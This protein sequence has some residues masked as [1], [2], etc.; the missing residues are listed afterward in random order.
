MFRSILGSLMC[1]CVVASQA[2]AQVLYN[3]GGFEPPRFTTTPFTSLEGQDSPPTGQG[4]WQKDATG[5]SPAFIQTTVVQSGLQAVQFNRVAASTGDT[6]YGVVK[7]TAAPQRISI[8]WDQRVNSGSANNP[9]FGV[10]A[11]DRSAGGAKLIGT[12]GLDGT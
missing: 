2:R 10:L 8:Q 3:S 9:F 1:L 12:A 5:T 4:P 7:P 6:F 11:F